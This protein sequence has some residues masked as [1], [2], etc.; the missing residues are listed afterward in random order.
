MLFHGF[1]VNV[2][3][4]M[5]EIDNLS[6]QDLPRSASSMSV[7]TDGTGVSAHIPSLATNK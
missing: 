1:T 4:W 2:D 3:E 6:V 7:H 5:Q